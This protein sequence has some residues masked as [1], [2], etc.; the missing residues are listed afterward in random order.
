MPS[1]VFKVCRML[2]AAH[3]HYFLERD[4]PDSIT[5]T[6][7]FVGERVEVDVF[8]DDHVEISRFR[9]DESIEG[10]MDLLRE[11]V[12]RDMEENY[13]DSPLPSELTE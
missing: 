9:G 6:V 1:A 11:L 12:K 5:I 7:S 4:R 13:P 3:L 2:D 8:E 10:E